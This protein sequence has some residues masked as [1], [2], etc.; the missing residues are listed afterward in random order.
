[1]GVRFRGLGSVLTALNA[2][3]ESARSDRGSVTVWVVCVIGTLCAVCGVLLAQGEAVLA[4]HRAAGAADLAALAA[5]DHWMEGGEAACATAGRV[6]GAQ[7]SRL[8]RCALVGDVSDVTAASASG[9]FTAEVRARAGP[10]EARAQRSPSPPVPHA[11]A[12]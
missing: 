3:A 12:P 1:M 5:A 9:P 10:A 11:T 4:R 8:V 7:G 2:R 6:A